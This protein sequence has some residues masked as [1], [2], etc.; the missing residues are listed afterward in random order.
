MNTPLRML[1]YANAI[2]ATRDYTVSTAREVSLGR[3]LTTKLLTAFVVFA[4]IGRKLV[5]EPLVSVEIAPTG[6]QE[7]VV[8]D[9]QTGSTK[10]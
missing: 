5:T 1:R 7:I 3:I 10:T 8:R 9:A 4:T 2:L 6:I